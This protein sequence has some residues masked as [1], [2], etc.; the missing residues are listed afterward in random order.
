MPA[1]LLEPNFLCPRSHGVVDYL[2]FTPCHTALL[3]SDPDQTACLPGVYSLG[4]QHKE[5]G[6]SNQLAAGQN[7]AE[8]TLP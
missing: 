5:Q 1:G 2:V 4:V 7:P 8:H 3:S 6:A